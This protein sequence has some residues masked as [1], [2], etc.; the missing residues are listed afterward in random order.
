LLASPAS[1]HVAWV[2]A[3]QGLVEQSTYVGV[4][5][6]LL[7]ASLGVP[8]PEEM[9]I[10]AAAVLAHEGLA[11]WWL[12]LPV[13]LAGVLSGDVILYWAGRVWGERILGWGPVRLV[14][15]PAREER[16]KAAYHRH[17]VKTIVTAR[18]VVGLR[19]AAFLTAGIAHVPFV[20][21][22]VIDAGAALVSVPIMFGLAYFFTDQLQAVL[23]DVRRVEGWL[24]MLAVVA[25]AVTFAVMAWRRQRRGIPD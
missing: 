13:C 2:D 15:T 20:R 9:P 18:H 12:A 3:V 19:A 22:I 1:W 10:V 5:L 7:L 21:F 25:I 11:R 14:L 23:A 17:A 24:A 8:I 16:L 6:A 4:F